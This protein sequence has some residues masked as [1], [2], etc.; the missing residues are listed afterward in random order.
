MILKIPLYYVK[1][2]NTRKT[3]ENVNILYF[4]SHSIKAK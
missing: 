3:A 1:N 4:A 2:K